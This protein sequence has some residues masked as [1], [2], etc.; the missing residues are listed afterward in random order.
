MLVSVSVLSHPHSILKGPHPMLNGPSSKLH[1]S[2]HPHSM[3]VTSRMRCSL[4]GLE[5]AP[6]V[7]DLSNS[8]CRLSGLGVMA[9]HGRWRVGLLR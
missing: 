7:L 8:Y 1:E 4:H 9:V 3:L 6:P 2:S 5:T